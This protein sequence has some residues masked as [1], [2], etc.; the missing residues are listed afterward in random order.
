MVLVLKLWHQAKAFTAQFLVAATTHMMVLSMATPHV[1]GVVGLIRS[2][3]KDLTSDQV[4]Q[5]LRN[6]AV[7]AGS[8]NEYGYGIVD[9]YAA[10]QAGWWTN[11]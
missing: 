8:T 9:A 6:T 5:I 11:R 10:V 2:V 3:N 1:V 4:R 7:N